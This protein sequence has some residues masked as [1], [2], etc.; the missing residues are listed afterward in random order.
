M[1]KLLSCVFVL[2]AFCASG[3]DFQ[4][5]NSYR[6]VLLPNQYGDG[7]P[8]R[9]G[10]LP[11]L[12]NKLTQKGL[13]IAV[14]RGPLLANRVPEQEI[15]VCQL[16]VIGNGYVGDKILTIS[17]LDAQR[18]VVK[19][20]NARISGVAISR[21][22]AFQNVL[23]NALQ[24]LMSAGYRHSYQ[25][26]KPVVSPSV[27]HET[28]PTAMAKATPAPVRAAAMPA[29][30]KVAAI[31]GGGEDADRKV[32]DSRPMFPGGKATL[33]TFIEENYRYP[34][35]AIVDKKAGRIVMSFLVDETGSIHDLGVAEGIRPDLDE[36][37]LRV[38]SKMPNWM[39]GRKNG[40]PVR[41][42]YRYTINLNPPANS[43]KR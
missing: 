31:G 20:L 13:P 27:D 5:L 10:L 6:F 19:Q 29:P 9:F 8:D 1:K 35:Q 26:P 23:D 22:K 36:E 37:A 42:R 18:K 16:D 17:F 2:A 39:P 38:M 30:A 41:V 21:K 11:I 33:R 25:A 7:T 43:A 40:V 3:Q 32:L 28:A 15:L 12:K 4:R 34:L 14:S 24:P